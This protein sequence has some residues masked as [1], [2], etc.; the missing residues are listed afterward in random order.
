[1]VVEVGGAGTLDQSIKALRPGGV[2][3]LIG[4]L[5]GSNHDFRLPLVVTRKI[6]ME[7]VTCGNRE[8]FESMLS[9]IKQH[10]L[11]P[12]LDEKTFSL[13]EI[14]SAFEYMRA[15]KHFGK[16]AIEM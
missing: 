14:V 15:G 7:G 4:V 8:Q 3:C 12:A 13:E 10:N 5:S 11:R 1:M 6:R 2:A 9:A 16:V